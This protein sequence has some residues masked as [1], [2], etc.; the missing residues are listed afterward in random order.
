[1]LHLF[2]VR[3]IALRWS[4][5]VVKI[6]AIGGMPDLRDDWTLDPTMVD[7]VP[8]DIFEERVCFDQCRPTNTV[9]RDVAQPLRRVD[10][11]AASDEVPSSR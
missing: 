8:V 5:V 10:S 11:T 3:S 1:M 6:A 4:T 7:G 2:R 9:L